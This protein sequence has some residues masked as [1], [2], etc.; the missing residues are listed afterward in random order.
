MEIQIDFNK[1]NQFIRLKL[2]S[3]RYAKQIINIHLLFSEEI[4]TR[5]WKQEI[6]SFINR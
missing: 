4:Y 2:I 3:N 6:T 5:R 1:K